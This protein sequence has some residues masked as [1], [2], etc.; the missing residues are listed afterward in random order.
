MNIDKDIDE[1]LVSISQEHHGVISTIEK[2]LESLP[3]YQNSYH[4]DLTVRKYRGCLCKN[5]NNFATFLKQNK[6]EF[7][8]ECKTD[9]LELYKCFV[10]NQVDLSTARSHITAARQLMKFAFKLGWVPI[11]YSNLLHLPKRSGPH[12]IK[13]VPQEVIKLILEQEWGRNP[14]V[15]ARNRL[16]C[17]LFAVRGLRPLE[18][19]RLKLTSIHPYKDLAYLWPVLGKKMAPRFVML[20]EDTLGVLKIYMIERAHFAL[21][22]R[23]KE[24]CLLLAEVPQNGTHQI[25]ISGIQA[26]I[27]RIKSELSLKGC[28]WDLSSL[29]PQGLRRSAE[30]NE[31]DRAEFL[32]INNPQLSI[33]GQFGHTQAISERYYW[34]KSKRNAYILAKGGK[35]VDKLRAEQNEEGIKWQIQEEFPETNLFRDLGLEI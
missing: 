35:I 11:D 5:P 15:V 13:T 18:M 32:P 20:D 7:I 29:N 4:S 33:P 3:G 9:V 17:Y 34:Q 2:Y 25:A 24:D 10:I 22:H 1:L 30:S 26:I 31:Y 21:R 12:I 14:F 19:P 8:E 27:R 16:I 6:V 28:L 23:I